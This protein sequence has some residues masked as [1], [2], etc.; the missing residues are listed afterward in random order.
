MTQEGQ[1]AF[2]SSSDSNVISAIERHEYITEWV[3]LNTTTPL[4]GL[5]KKNNMNNAL[6][7][8][9]FAGIGAIACYYIFVKENKQ[10]NAKF[11]K[12]LQK[13]RFFDKFNYY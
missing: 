6:L 4:I 12:T 13:Q 3:N 7:L 2:Y 9:S 11:R 5:L 8:V 1:T 10:N